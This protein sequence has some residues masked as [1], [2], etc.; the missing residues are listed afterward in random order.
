M[1]CIPSRESR[2]TPKTFQSKKPLKNRKQFSQVYLNSGNI[3]RKHVSDLQR[4]G[5]LN[6]NVEHS[7]Y[8]TSLTKA[9]VPS[10]E[11]TRSNTLSLSDFW[12]LSNF[13][14]VSSNSGF[15]TK[16]SPCIL[17]KT[18]WYVWTAS[19]SLRDRSRWMRAIMNNCKFSIVT[20]DRIST[21]IA[22]GVRVF[23]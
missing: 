18:F 6:L 4:Q 21:S 2:T 14:I 17:K 7:N 9:N 19:K 23:A 3:L 12:T 11:V 16:T 22:A 15:A 8:N 13:S 1:P 5:R 20:K 10:E